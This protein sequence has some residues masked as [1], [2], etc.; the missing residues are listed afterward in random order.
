MVY[1][2]FAFAQHRGELGFTQ[3][4]IMS[5]VLTG[6]GKLEARN[7]VRA[8]SE[9]LKWIEKCGTKEQGSPIPHFVEINWLGLEYRGATITPYKWPS[10]TPITPLFRRAK[11]LYNTF[12]GKF[13]KN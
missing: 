5:E 11:D 3:R 4:D 1:S 6:F 8:L 9:K 10:I 2:V 13:L 12:W 7:V